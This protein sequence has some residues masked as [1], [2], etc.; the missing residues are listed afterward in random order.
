MEGE[1]KARTALFLREGKKKST[2]IMQR[3]HAGGIDVT[4]HPERKKSK[5]RSW[6]G[7]WPP[8]EVGK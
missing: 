4:G 5:K 6:P 8:K 3:Q 7:C 2:N 1:K